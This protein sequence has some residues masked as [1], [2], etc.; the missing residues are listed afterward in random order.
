MRFGLLGPPAVHDAVGVPHPLGSAKVRALLGALLLR[1]NRVVPVDELKDA[2]WG[3]DPPASAHASLHN[4]VTRLRRLLAEKDRLRAV[5]PGYLLRIEPGELDTDVFETYARTARAAHSQGDWPAVLEAARAGLALWRGSPLAGLYDPDDG[6]PALVQRLRESRLLVLEWRYDAELHLGRHGTLGPELAALVAEFPLRE[7]FHRQLMLTL[8]RAGRQAEALAAYR[9]LR[10]TLVEELGVDPGPAVQEAHQ[11]VLR[12][13]AAQPAPRPSSRLPPPPRPAQL[14]PPPAHFTGRDAQFE[15]LRAA[16]TGEE[17]PAVVVV[18]G[19]AG[20]GKSALAAQVAHA[21][22]EEFP[23]G[24]LYCNLHGATPGMPPLDPG[25]A[26]CALLRDLGVDPRQVPDEVDAA[27]ALLRSTLA[28]TRTLL[29]LDDV[30][31]AAQ[32]RPLLP[33]GPGCAVVVTSRSPLTALDG[34]ARFP[35]A[36]LSAADSGTLLRAVSGRGSGEGL[37]RLVERCGRLPLALRIV[38]ARL[39]ARSALTA[40]A[41]AGLLDAEAGRLDHLEY[42]DLSVR[43]SLAVAHDGLDPDAALALRRLGAVDLPEY[44]APAVARLMETDERR[45]AVALDRLVEVALLEEVSYGRFVPHDLV[46]DFA[47]ELA[48]PDDTLE[49]AERVLRW[50]GECARQAGVALLPPGQE[51]GL[52]LPPP[53]GEAAPFDSA[54]QALA[55]IDREL[56]NVV[57]LTERYVRQSTTVLLLVRSCFPSLQRRGRIQELAVL[58]ELALGAARAAGDTEAEGHALTDLAGMN[59]L[60]GRPERALSLNEEAITIWRALGEDRRVQR[61]LGNRGMLLEGLGRHTEAAETLE[62]AIEFARCLDDAHGE[63][64]ILSHLGNLY[65]HTDAR[66]AIGYHERSLTAG[67]RLRSE[68]LL[69]TAH[70]NIG[71]AHLTLGEPGEAV[72]HFDESL[73]ILGDDGD[74]HSQSQSRIGRVRALRGVGRDGEARRECALLLERAESRADTHMQARARHQSG[75]LFRAEG[76][77]EEAREQWRRALATLQALDGEHARLLDELREL[78]SGTAA[79]D[80]AGETG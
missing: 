34:A 8:H 28:P 64:V 40:D 56:P 77:T 53:I 20:V 47:R 52:R 33:A 12:A 29:V 30:A 7:A 71:Y 25:H 80:V 62:S 54:E 75:L 76:R 42:D 3:D 68:P 74:W 41:L 69:H 51:A 38:A 5:S 26:L 18:S 35:L 61:G 72:K 19:M 4:H 17:G 21:L 79:C 73:A 16:L 6:T 57:A 70:C 27:A 37:E 14:P 36:P 45:A 39:A 43:G 10:R 31:S 67:V 59:F 58:N 55:W 60:S 46:R 48:A 23:D 66:A 50:Y 15:E 11:E 9:S 65:E 13:P 32:V 78:M 24:Q 1:P 22:R 44:G 2:L 63:A 49:V